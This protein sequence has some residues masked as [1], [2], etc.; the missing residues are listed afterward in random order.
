VPT[1]PIHQLAEPGEILQE[2]EKER[3]RLLEE[4]E[5]RRRDEEMASARLIAEL[6]AQQEAERA[7]AA[8]L[9][10]ILKE[11]EAL[12]LMLSSPNA[13]PT[14]HENQEIERTPISSTGRKR[15]RKSPTE[16]CSSSKRISNFFTSSKSLI[17]FLGVERPIQNAIII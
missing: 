2:F 8:E 15:T 6:E 5:K 3:Q 13:G 9:E 12:A 4:E 17:I 16:G 10:R 1:V 7:R 14:Q 11:D